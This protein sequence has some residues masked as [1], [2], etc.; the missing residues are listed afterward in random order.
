MTLRATDCGLLM[1]GKN[2]RGRLVQWVEKASLEK[3]RRLLEVSEQERHCEV[4]LTLKNL[5]NVRRS[6]APYSLPIIPRSLPLEIVGRKHF[7]TTDLLDLLAGRAP[8]P[9][10]PEAE[11][12]SREQALQASSIPSTSTSG[13]S[14][15]ALPVPSLEAGSI[16][17]TGLPLPRKMIYPAPRV[18]T[19]KKKR[20]T[21]K[22]SAR[23]VRSEPSQPSLKEEEEEE[24]E[25]TGLLDRYVARKRKRQEEAKLEAERAEG[26]VL[27]PM[28][29]G[30]EIQTIVIPAS[31]EM[32]V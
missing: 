4:L 22:K 13:G 5:T 17:S 31:P 1:Q 21:Q 7:V 14:S 24:E 18:L 2:W 19:I 10:D 28:D 30:S 27:P 15:S 25:M 29:G 26:S 9:G 11:A 8:L 16:C 6:P 32:G 23:G 20:T 3:I 12:L